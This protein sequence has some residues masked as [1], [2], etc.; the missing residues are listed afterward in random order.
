M[1]T[2]PPARPQRADLND[3]GAWR[4]RFLVRLAAL[5]PG[6]LL[7]DLLRAAVPAS[8]PE[9]L[10]ATLA[11]YVDTLL[12]ADALTPAASALGVHRAILDDAAGNAFLQRLF[13][14]GSRWL[15]Q[16]ADGP[17]RDATPAVRT[18]VVDW[19]AS[20]PLQ[21]VPRRFYEILRAQAIERYYSQ[22]AALAGLALTRPP[23][24]LGYPE[25]WA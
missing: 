17:F 2:P 22:P 6:L 23:Q 8:D 16:A 15:D 24:P 1:T 13:E 20:A 5:G 3:G 21:H 4:R 11:A 10:A 18:V 7:P 12:P 9:P 19:M 14:V 25:P